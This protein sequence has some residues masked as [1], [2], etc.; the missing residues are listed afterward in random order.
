MINETEK[1]EKVADRLTLLRQWVVNSRRRT[2]ALTIT[3]YALTLA[4]TTTSYTPNAR[5]FH[6]LATPLPFTSDA[7]KRKTLI[8]IFDSQ[9]ANIRRSGP[10]EYY[11]KLELLLA[12]SESLHE[13]DAGSNRVLETYLEISELDVA[14]RVNCL[15]ALMATL[16]E[17]DP[18]S[19]LEEREGLHS[20]VEVELREAI[21]DLLRRSA[22]H[23][24]ATRR[25]IRSLSPS[26]IDFAIGVVQQLNT[27]NSR[28]RASL[29]IIET[30]IENELVLIQVDS[31]SRIIK[32]IS[33]GEVS[34]DAIIS[35]LARLDNEGALSAT[36]LERFMPWFRL[37]DD[38][39]DAEER[40]QALC[41]A[42][43]ILTK[44]GKEQF[45]GLISALVSKLDSAWRSN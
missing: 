26:N 39:E 18:T 28:N 25:M 21:N 15:A 16:F 45:A 20:L 12:H 14:I 6:D 42:I 1:L 24:K 17:M 7:A 27:E 35:A 8:G 32:S 13:F 41:L 31:I 40:C 38:V 11:I 2:D 4:V 5:L 30:H 22:D 10:T 29:D 37:M 19:V 23:Y 36:E 3:E 9:K 44:A 43:S 33:I 34:S